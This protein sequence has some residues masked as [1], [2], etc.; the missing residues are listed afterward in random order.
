MTFAC[1]VKILKEDYNIWKQYTQ[2]NTPK[3]FY[4]FITLTQKSFTDMMS[5]FF[6]RRKKEFFIFMKNWLRGKKMRK[7]ISAVPAYVTHAEV[8]WL[9]PTVN[10]ENLLR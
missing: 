2:K 7:L 6:R 4:A 9:S 3:D 10:W 1:S 8:K 5:F